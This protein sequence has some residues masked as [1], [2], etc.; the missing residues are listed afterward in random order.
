MLFI[1]L[2]WFFIRVYMMMFGV[3]NY[4]N[5]LMEVEDYVEQ[6]KFFFVLF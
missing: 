4:V 1:I 3:Y 5:W 6:V 2:I